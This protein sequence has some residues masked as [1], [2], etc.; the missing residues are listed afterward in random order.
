[1][2]DVNSWVEKTRQ[3][4]GTSTVETVNRLREPFTPGDQTLVMER[5]V[6]QVNVGQVICVGLNAF[7]VWSV[8]ASSKT[9]EIE[10][11]WAGSPEV[12]VSAGEIARMKPTV[13]THS[14]LDALN[15]ALQ[16]MS[17]PKLSVHGVATIDL[18][19]S[20]S[21]T[22]YDLSDT[23]NLLRVLYVAYGDPNDELTLWGRLTPTDWELVKQEPTADKPG[24]AYLRVFNGRSP[25]RGTN[26]P[27][28]YD[29]SVR[30]TYA[31]GTNPL[32]SLDMEV[33]S[34]GLPETA[35]D[36]PPLGAA[37]RLAF[38]M[39]YRR[40]LMQSQPDTRRSDETPPGAVL[41]GARTLRAMFEDRC[42]QESSRFLQ[43]HPYIR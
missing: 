29:Q 42:A 16:E 9:I 41:G 8:D 35:W 15:D 11:S 28:I 5:A 12:A 43:A 39:E 26:W 20:E 24:G 33:S 34:S 23:E 40:N 2:L 36:I 21:Q 25:S 19:Y 37:A 38:P 32:D 31:K 4:L 1:M 30:V 3:L 18:P 14:I 10:S 7:L 13:Y 17:S 6:D 22:V 27:D